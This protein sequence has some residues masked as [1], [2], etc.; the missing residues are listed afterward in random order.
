L[1]ADE[2]LGIYSTGLS[3]KH[4]HVGQLKSGPSVKTYALSEARIVALCK[5][6]VLLS[7]LATW[8]RQGASTT[9][10]P[11]LTYISSVWKFHEGSWR[12]VF[13]QDTRAGD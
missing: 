4:D 2:F 1:L 6:V 3:G 7:Y 8:V 13:S 11:E 10:T 12:N 5:D 9:S